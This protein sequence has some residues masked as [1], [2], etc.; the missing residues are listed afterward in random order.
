MNFYQNIIFSVITTILITILLGKF[1]IKQLRKQEIG[2]EIRDDGPKSHLKKEG[3]PT[4]G[5]IIFLLAS[6]I[7]T[8]LFRLWTIEIFIIWMGIFTFG[9]IGFID[10]FLKLVMKRSLGL[11]EKQKLILQF[12]ASFI[13]IFLLVKFTNIPIFDQRIPFTNKFISFGPIF[14]SLFLVFV[15]LGTVNATNLTDGLDGL[16]SSVSIPVFITL[17]ILAKTFYP[18]I[19]LF[20]AI[21]AGSLLG[22]LAYNSYPASVFMGDTGSM[23]FGGALVTICTLFQMNFYLMILGGIYMIEVLSVIIQMLSYRYRNKK[24]VFLMSPIHH[25]FE[26]KGHHETK[27][28][29]NFTIISVLLSLITLWDLLPKL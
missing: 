1:I 11:N 26:L 29:T 24:R 7:S 15:M 18:E 21:F 8:F 12:L 20:S 6:L 28:V 5:G 17:S 23:A 2:Q 22:F 25:H 3:T 19:S 4:M 9:G 16:S 14:G 10:D 13:M 27:I